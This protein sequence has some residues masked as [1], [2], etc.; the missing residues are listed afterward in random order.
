M[1]DEILETTGTPP[2]PGFYEDGSGQQRWWDGSG[3]G[4]QRVATAKQP[5]GSLW[6]TAP[7]IFLSAL[8]PPLGL[9]YGLLMKSSRHK[10]ANFV[11]WFSFGM[12]LLYAVLLMVVV[13]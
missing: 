6:V 7:G 13:G 12:F 9:I 10:D 11:M 2:P 3:W 1:Q 4:E 8:S 5:K